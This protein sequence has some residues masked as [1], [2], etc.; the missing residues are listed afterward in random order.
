[1]PDIQEQKD[2]A[3]SS[4]YA[5]ETT[6]KATAD[7]T[8]T[9]AML[10]RRQQARTQSRTAQE[11]GRRKFK[12]DAQSKLIQGVQKTGN[13][14][15]AFAKKVAAAA[16]N[17]AKSLASALVIGLGSMGV[18]M[19]LSILL[20]VG[21]IVASPFGIFFSNE[22]S[23]DTIPLSSAVSQ[24]NAE[25][26]NRLYEVQEGEYDDITI[27]GRPPDWCEVIAVFA[28]LTAGAE[29]SMDVAALDDAQIAKLSAVFWD[30]CGIS[31]S[32]E[33]IEHPD[34]DLEDDVDDSWTETILHI[35]ITSKNAEQMRSIYAFTD[36]QNEC[37]T[38]L[39]SDRTVLSNLIGDLE[40]VQTDAVWLLQSLPEDLSPERKAI[41]QKALTL[42]G[43]V[44]YFWGGKSLALGWDSRWGQLQKVTAAGS[45]TTGTFRPFGL[46]C[47]GFVDWV[48]Y[49]A[50]GC[51]YII[52]HGGGA[53]SQHNYCTPISWENAQPGDLVFYADNSHVGIIGGVDTQGNPLIIHC[54]SSANNVVIT[55]LSDFLTVGRPH[56]FEE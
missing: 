16:T 43:K 39:L 7:Y 3:Y 51:A 53:A 52:G 54:S 45:E 48:F 20:L 28:N 17:T 12:R 56:Y 40:I 18:V 55:G 30:M 22:P 36:F 11:A 13:A 46:D 9:T 19:I 21:A 2:S 26:S 5:V 24:I 8:R 25:F 6:K 38:E 35:T 23:A 32:T 37:L 42:V 49:N 44:N 27:K 14:T 47:S 33:R 1:M 34:S 50:S 31:K 41:V 4:E 15:M 29:D 10:L